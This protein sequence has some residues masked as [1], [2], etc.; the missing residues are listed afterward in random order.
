MHHPIKQTLHKDH[1]SKYSNALVYFFATTTP[2]FMLPQAIEIFRSHHAVNVALLTWVFFLLADVVW[3]F[4]GVKHKLKPLVYC[5]IL[6]FV[7]EAFI[8]AGII[9]YR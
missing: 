9:I 4:Y 2:L 7:V 8:V 3:I 5:H 1:Q 6:Y